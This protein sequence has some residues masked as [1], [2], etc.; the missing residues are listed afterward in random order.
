MHQ[1][2]SGKNYDNIS[3][4]IGSLTLGLE[5]FFSKLRIMACT[6]VLSESAISGLHKKLC[7]ILPTNIMYLSKITKE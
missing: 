1:L 5:A 2:P 4:K 6:R 7:V 3:C